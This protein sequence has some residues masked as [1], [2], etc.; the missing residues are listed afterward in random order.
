MQ[1]KRAGSVATKNKRT[2]TEPTKQAQASAFVTKMEGLSDRTKWALDR[3]F[4]TH[5]VGSLMPFQMCSRLATGLLTGVRS[6]VAGHTANS[7]DRDYFPLLNLSQ[8]PGTGKSRTLDEIPHFLS[9]QLGEEV[10]MFKRLI[11]LRAEYNGS[12]PL[13]KAISGTDGVFLRLLY[14]LFN[15]WREF[16][17]FAYKWFAVE[18]TPCIECDFEL[19][20]EI[21]HCAVGNSRFGAEQYIVL[22]LLDGFSRL[23]SE[24]E[25]LHNN[26]IW[27]IGTEMKA[28]WTS[29]SGPLLLPVVASTKCGSVVAAFSPDGTPQPVITLRS[30]PFYGE[31][32]ITIMGG[33]EQKL[34]IFKGWQLSPGFR[35]NLCIAGQH[36]RTLEKFLTAIMEERE[37]HEWSEID[38]DVS[39]PPLPSDMAGIKDIPQEVIDVILAEAMLG[40][41]ISNDPQDFIHPA[42]T[43]T[44]EELEHRQLIWLQST[45]GDIFR[46]TMSPL[47]FPTLS[48]A[49]KHY[50]AVKSVHGNSPDWAVWEEFSTR[51]IAARFG[52]VTSLMGMDKC[53]YT[54]KQYGR[55][56][57]WDTKRVDSQLLF[58]GTVPGIMLDAVPGLYSQLPSRFPSTK[59]MPLVAGVHRNAAGAPFDAV[60]PQRNNSV[61]AIQCFQVTKLTYNAVQ[62]EFNK[63]TKACSA[64]GIEIILFVA[65]STR[66]IEGDTPHGWPST[67][68]IITG[69]NRP[70]FGPFAFRPIFDSLFVLPLDVNLATCQQLEQI[71]GKK[72][73]SV[74]KSP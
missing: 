73:A 12:T 53:P 11:V 52:A 35:R 31:E 57:D 59:G 68:T 30:R 64:A 2:R 49:S 72:S 65:L 5:R 3:P 66:S 39:V 58:P 42:F 62:N 55:L 71:I 37:T 34:P 60:V 15:E 24:N 63:S 44:Y 36:P 54:N 50:R 74:K 23:F 20:L 47:R 9:D 10:P 13:N 21:V 6:M 8:E 33:L 41:E 7:T 14:S 28:S 16:H 48:S 18:K 61:I 17:A 70:F 25:K 51:V 29:K 38:F 22:V 32:L 43:F 1:R 26:I 46:V 67:C 4:A 56:L 45:R 40:C 19:L 27:S 69:A